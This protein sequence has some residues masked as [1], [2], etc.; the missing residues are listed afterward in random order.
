[1]T[2]IK[3]IY[4]DFMCDSS[5]KTQDRQ[6]IERIEQIL[7][8]IRPLHLLNPLMAFGLFSA[9]SCALLLL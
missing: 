7:F 6:R 1:M 9:E 2:Q 3:R 8:H 5:E 4:T